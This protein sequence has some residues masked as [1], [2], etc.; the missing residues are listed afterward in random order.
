MSQ[1]NWDFN[2]NILMVMTHQRLNICIY[3][4]ICIVIETDSI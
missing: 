1:V 2:L 3:K 4:F